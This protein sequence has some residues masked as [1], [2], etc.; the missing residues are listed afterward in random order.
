MSRVLPNKS[1]DKLKMDKNISL[2]INKKASELDA[3]E[4]NELSYEDAI[5][6]DQREF[7]QIYWDL[8]KREHIIIFTFFVY[9]DYN[10]SSIKYAK[11]IFLF[12]S[13][14]ALNILFFN[15]ASMHKVFLNYGKYNFDQQI[16]K[17]LYSTIFS[18]MI[19][20]FLCYLSMIDKHF[21]Q[22]KNLNQ[23]ERKKRKSILK[24]IE[25]KLIYFFLFTFIVLG[26]YWYLIA[27]FC[28]VYENTQI[29]FIKDSLSSNLIGMA[30]QIFIYLIPASLRL[31]SIR[32]KKIDFK[33]FYK[34]S[35][36]IPFF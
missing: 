6:F 11:F 18:Q 7:I 23:S 32:Y 20:V 36:I 31:C 24:C 17:I 4:L 19:E 21:Y 28:A 1:N 25:I 22:I 26:F 14:M 12:A 30:Y 3:Y 33:C 8:L 16:P 5:K 27:S 29:I 10:L 15:D 34:L 35:D 9:D 2:N 13:D